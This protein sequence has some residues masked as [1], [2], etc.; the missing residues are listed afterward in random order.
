VVE[1]LFPGAP[2]EVTTIY[3]RDGNDMVLT[4]DCAGGNQPRM[5]ARTVDRNTVAFE[6][7]GGTHFNPAVDPHMHEAQIEFISADE[8]RAHWKSWNKGQPAP[9]SP[10]FR[11]QRK[12]S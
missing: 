5:R 10:N 11:L 9:H 1:T 4:H 3:H 2:H 12:K 8:I 6:F 7:D